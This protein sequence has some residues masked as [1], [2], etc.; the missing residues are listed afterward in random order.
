MNFYE[1]RDGAVAA[2]G[3][4]IIDIRN[5]H[6]WWKTPLDS[7]DLPSIR[8]FDFQSAD[9]MVFASSDESLDH[10]NTGACWVDWKGR[11]VDDLLAELRDM[12]IEFSMRGI[13]MADVLRELLKIRQF[14]ATGA[15]SFY[16]ARAFSHAV[17]GSAYEDLAYWNKFKD[18]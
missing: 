10:S 8:V 18:E 12:A 2:L 11:E 14:V 4:G 5:A 15:S 13:P 16:L 7:D 1:K 6:I 17:A 3:V 9:D